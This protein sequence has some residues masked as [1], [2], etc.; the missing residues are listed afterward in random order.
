MPTRCGAFGKTD[1]SPVS[2]AATGA[3]GPDGKAWTTPEGIRN[4][5]MTIYRIPRLARSSVCYFPTRCWV[6]VL[7]SPQMNSMSS[8]SAIRR[9]VAS[10]VQG[11]V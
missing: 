11:V 9:C 4:T 5:G 3:V 7:F 6:L 1:V 10:T 8:S 2:L